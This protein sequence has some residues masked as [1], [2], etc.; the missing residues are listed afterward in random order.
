MTPENI[1]AATAASPA[2]TASESLPLPPTESVE[3]SAPPQLERNSLPF[4]LTIGQQFVTVYFGIAYLLP[5]VGNVLFDEYIVSSYIIMPLT[6]YAAVMI[7]GVYVLFLILST[8]NI[9]SGIVPGASL[10]RPMALDI[11]AIYTG[12][13]PFIAVI[14]ALF[15]AMSLISGSVGYRYGAQGISE[16]NSPLLV[17]LIVLRIIIGLDLFYCMFVKAGETDKPFTRRYLQNI[18]L[19]ATLLISAN[20]VADAFFSLTTVLYSV[21][22]RVF[23][24]LVFM[25]KSGPALIAWLVASVVIILFI[26]AGA[27]AWGNAVKA[28]AGVGDLPDEPKVLTVF[29]RMSEFYLT[30]P[31][32]LS[33][34]FY[35]LIE[36]LS[37]YYYSYLFTVESTW[38]FLNR[39]E[40]TVLA[41]PLRSFLFRIDYLT[42]GMFGMVRPDISSIMQ[43]N[44]QL[45]TLEPTNTREGS[46]PGAIGAFNYVF[47]HPVGPILCAFYLSW[48]SKVIDALFRQH[49]QELLS[50]FSAVLL[51]FYLGPFFQSPFDWL[52]VIDDGLIYLVLVVGLA[53]AEERSTLPEGSVS[54][55]TAP[56]S[57]GMALEQQ[58]A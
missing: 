50:V 33:T 14:A 18:L 34:Y 29:A 31:D 12:L 3:P 5:M 21:F 25:P 30:D 55:A 38:E 41:L 27:S 56:A 40:L 52:L 7:I 47:S 20:G 35:Y 17:I 26:A 11:G 28:S 42:S 45:L 8:V 48:V 4:F 53:S 22:P 43:L 58:E 19:S 10:I 49:Q 2:T 57:A 32:S 1:P 39:G 6:L 13:R 24:R 37:I 44:Y 36:R 16:L 9:P 23:K 51:F 54:T 15:A 46:S